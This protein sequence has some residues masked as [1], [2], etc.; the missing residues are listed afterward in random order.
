[1]LGRLL[2]AWPRKWWVELFRPHTFQHPKNPV[3]GPFCG[4]LLT[5]FFCRFLFG[6]PNQQCLE[7]PWFLEFFSGET[8]WLLQR[9]V[10]QALRWIFSFNITKKNGWNT[11]M[12]LS[13]A[14]TKTWQQILLL[15]SR[16]LT[17][18]WELWF[19]LIEHM[20]FPLPILYKVGL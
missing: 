4:G 9:S 13:P 20:D 11:P 14:K 18:Q 7:I 5:L 1:M 10:L 17:W 2:T 3:I 8:S 15:P 19:F 6:S 12:I 16:K